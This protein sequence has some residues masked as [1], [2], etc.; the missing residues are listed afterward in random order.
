MQTIYFSSG[1]YSTQGYNNGHF[2]PFQVCTDYAYY[3]LCG[4]D[5]QYRQESK[6]IALHTYILTHLE[7]SFK[8]PL[9]CGCRW[10]WL[11]KKK[12]YYYRVPRP[13][14]PT[15]FVVFK[16]QF[17]PKVVGC[18]VTKYEIVVSLKKKQEKTEAF[19]SMF[20]ILA[21]AKWF[22]GKNLGRYLLAEL[23]ISN[24]IQACSL[25][26]DNRYTQLGALRI[27]FLYWPGFFLLIK[28][29]IQIIE[30]FFLTLL[31]LVTMVAQY[32]RHKCKINRH[33]FNY[34]TF[35]CG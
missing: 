24:L 1:R 26:K 22:A 8:Q 25:Q 23:L 4:G 27:L 29:W 16:V 15:K 14:F 19:S 9:I 12:V 31:M 10:W 3:T 2:G 21:W 32:C 34:V 30:V 6:Y 7:K 17:S 13:S 20:L 5:T 28:I 18:I 11:W 33:C 35:C